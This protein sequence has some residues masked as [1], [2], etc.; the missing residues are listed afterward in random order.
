M[1]SEETQ[2]KTPDHQQNQDTNQICPTSAPGRKISVPGPTTSV[3]SLTA[4]VPGL[5][6]SVTVLNAASVPAASV[7]A[8]SVPLWVQGPAL[9]DVNDGVRAHGVA[10]QY[11]Q[12]MKEQYQH[13]HHHLLLLLR[14][15]ASAD[16][17]P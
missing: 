6:T 9:T 5:T 16:P 14:P 10:S 8:A 2:V 7:P 13:L 1:R 12:G 15:G 17:R 3:P 11:P 4:S